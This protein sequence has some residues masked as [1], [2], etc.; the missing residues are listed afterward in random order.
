MP[1]F[2]FIAGI[3]TSN[4]EEIQARMLSGKKWGR[5]D[6]INMKS[7]FAQEWL[8]FKRKLIAFGICCLLYEYT[9]ARFGLQSH[10]QCMTRPFNKNAPYLAISQG[11]ERILLPKV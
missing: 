5:C 6:A 4:L 11:K 9:T 10:E 3:L 7:L 1:K 8:L 2:W